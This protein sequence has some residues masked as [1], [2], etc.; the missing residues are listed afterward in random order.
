MLV[1]NRLADVAI[2]PRRGRRPGPAGG[3]RA[4]L[5]VPPG[6]G[7]RRAVP[8][9]RQP[10]AVAVAGGPVRH[11]SGQRHRAV[12]G[13]RCGSRRTGSGCSPTRPPPG[14][15]PPTGPGSRPPSSISSP[16]S[17]AGASCPWSTCP[18]A[19]VD[20]CWHVTLLERQHRSTVASALRRFLTTPE[21]MQ[22]M[23][24]PTAGRAAVAVPAAGLRDDL[25]LA[26]RPDRPPRSPEGTVKQALIRV[27][28]APAGRADHVAHLTEVTHGQPIQGRS[29]L[30]RIESDGHSRGN[31]RLYEL[32]ENAPKEGKS[33]TVWAWPRADRLPEDRRSAGGRA[34]AAASGAPPGSGG[35]H[36]ARGRARPGVAAPKPPQVHSAGE[37]GGQCVRHRRRAPE[38]ND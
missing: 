36:A 21:A 18:G 2:G 10:P 26:S 23:R 9:A 22:L 35:G 31:P 14:P 13:R 20:G 8:A 15:R 19:P 7:H 3:E 25:E 1:G 37:S 29:G 27:L 11:R 33:P 17:C 4:D 34:V 30:M 16:S 12:A 6:R 28:R 32:I 38:T 5:P 24:A